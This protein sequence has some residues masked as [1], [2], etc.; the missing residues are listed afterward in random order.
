IAHP[1]T[2]LE[3]GTYTGYSAI[4]LAEGLSEDG[5]L[6]TI[7]INEELAPMQRKYFEKAGIAHRVIQHVGDAQEIIP[8]IDLKWDIVFVD[9]DK[10]NYINYYEQVI[11]NMNPNGLIIFDNVLWSGKVIEQVD[12]T[13]H[14]T[15]TL[16]RLN[17][18][19][20]KDDRVANLLLPIRDGLLIARKVN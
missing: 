16:I 12:P 9:A 3:I 19:I 13:D 15:N 5:V 10:E 2:I 17:E 14:E 6:H 8:S 18:L 11:D 20:H 7:D 4:C 1:R